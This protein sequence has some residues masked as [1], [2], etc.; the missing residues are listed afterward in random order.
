MVK[1]HHKV[2]QKWHEMKQNDATS[3]YRQ[4]VNADASKGNIYAK[5]KTPQ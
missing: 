2:G 4:L 1:K 5:Q 3:K